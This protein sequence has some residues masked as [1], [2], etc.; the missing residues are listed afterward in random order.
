MACYGCSSHSLW[1]QEIRNLHVHRHRLGL[2][3]SCLSLSPFH[4]HQVPWLQLRVLVY[5]CWL[6]LLVFHLLAAQGKEKP[7]P[8][9]ALLWFSKCTEQVLTLWA[10]LCTP[11]V[12]EEPHIHVYVF[13]RI[14]RLAHTDKQPCAYAFLCACRNPMPAFLNAKGLCHQS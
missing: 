3:S 13:L 9:L 1:L 2:C 5:G 7:A 14:C 8:G 4:Q 12:T 6:F 10:W 11:L